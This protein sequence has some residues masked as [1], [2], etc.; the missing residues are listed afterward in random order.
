MTSLVADEACREGSTEQCSMSLLQTRARAFRSDPEDT[1]FEQSA[2]D[3]HRDVKPSL[4][5]H[6]QRNK[7]ISGKYE[8]VKEHV[9]ELVEQRLEERVRA[10]G[11]QLAA[12]QKKQRET[13]QAE[14]AQKAEVEKEAKEAK[15]V[16]VARE[17]NA[18]QTSIAAK[19]AKVAR[20]VDESEEKEGVV[21]VDG[22]SA[23]QRSMEEAAS[24][25]ATA[26]AGAFARDSAKKANRGKNAASDDAKAA[27]EASE[28]TRENKVEERENVVSV[29]VSDMQQAME[30]AASKK[31]EAFEKAFARDA[32]ERASRSKHVVSVTMPAASSVAQRIV[33]SVR[34]HVIG[35]IAHDHQIHADSTNVMEDPGEEGGLPFRLFAEQGSIEVDKQG[36]NSTAS[37]N[38][39]KALHKVVDTTTTNLKKQYDLLNQAM[40]NSS[41]LNTTKNN[42]AERYNLVKGGMTNKLSRVMENY[43][44]VPDDTQVLEAATQENLEH[45][46]NA[47]VKHADA[48]VAADAHVVAEPHVVAATA[49]GAV[50]ATEKDNTDAASK[51]DAHSSSTSPPAAIA[52]D[53]VAETDILEVRSPKS[54][55]SLNRL[56]HEEVLKGRR[57]DVVLA[58]QEEDGFEVKVD[59]TDRGD[60]A[61]FD[62]DTLEQE[63]L[64][65]HGADEEVSDASDNA[66][67]KAEVQAKDA[68]DKTVDKI[69]ERA[70]EKAKKMLDRATPSAQS[71]TK[72]AIQ[73]KR[74]WDSRG[75]AQPN[76]ELSKNDLYPSKDFEDNLTALGG[77]RFKVAKI[78]PT[79]EA[80]ELKL[81]DPRENS[82]SAEME[83]SQKDVQRA[84]KEIAKSAIP[85]VSAADKAAVADEDSTDLEKDSVLAEG[86]D[87]NSA[88]D[89]N[90]LSGS[91]LVTT[92]GKGFTERANVS[93][94]DVLATNA[95]TPLARKA[96]TVEAFA[97]I[98]GKD[99][100]DVKVGHSALQHGD[101][102]N[103]DRKQQVFSQGDLP[104]FAIHDQDDEDLADDQAADPEETGVM[105]DKGRSLSEDVV[106]E[107]RAEEE[108][109]VLHARQDR[110]A[111]DEDDDGEYED[112]HEGEQE[113]EQEP[114]Q[115]S[116]HEGE[117]EDEEDGDHEED[118]HDGDEEGEH[119]S[120][121]DRS[122]D[123][124]EPD[125]SDE[126]GEAEEA[127]GEEEE[128]EEREEEDASLCDPG[129]SLDFSAATVTTN[130][131]G[132]FGPG[133]ASLV[134]QGVASLHGTEVD[135]VVIATS[136]YFARD[137]SKNGLRG[138]FGVVNIQTDT[139]VDLLLTFVSHETG[140]AVTMPPF[141]FTFFDLDQG[142]AHGS[143]EQVTIR[144]FDSYK[145]SDETQLA[146]EALPDGSGA[147]FISRQRGGKLDNPVH[148]TSLTR[149]QRE[150]TVTAKMPATSHFSVSLADSDYAATQ[151]RNFFFSGSSQ[152]VCERDHKCSDYACPDGFAVR[153][154]AE[155][156]L[157]SGR[158]CDDRDRDVCCFRT[159]ADQHNDAAA[160][161]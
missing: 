86:I 44:S 99:N 48:N 12:E 20:E 3:H 5:A 126:H 125:E 87:S 143:R 31:A 29:D 14:E 2:D 91:E 82:D 94:D 101:R 97:N 83:A 17:T 61:E 120:A 9:R 27:K 133:N 49:R 75:N 70:E 1:A 21:S 151:G 155:F 121:E 72:L 90:H 26:A 130:N 32:D 127:Q 160:L 135:L 4:E 13:Q 123:P 103:K 16:R 95:K 152:L 142:M 156:L 63:A 50:A 107:I 76:A 144:G 116:D 51:I 80:K 40:Q 84:F 147:R 139:S 22:E 18:A 93:S 115:E 67:T 154:M 134:Y 145:V 150:R 158:T 74:D 60:D 10:V 141:Y 54:P 64:R 140:Q 73:A 102:S 105:D 129:R 149:L 30:D 46:V 119:E 106:S 98:L 122:E 81:P 104:D 92:A 57:D 43:A 37:S 85:Q 24:K 59:M 124:D 47:T 15:A 89:S 42:L 33:P 56:Y 55:R 35:A 53:D 71:G 137:I 118:E 77:D 161:G 79:V 41:I 153:T 68:L 146:V 148:P 58:H 114:K 39:S 62:I 45:G 96:A 52:R 159:E 11:G 8:S 110:D 7:T 38:A 132:N 111:A 157:C 25:K 69:M 128:E 108:Q 34:R 23:G 138:P 6:L 136:P 112:E 131:L 19:V 65:M 88:Q 113:R 109:V 28:A 100:D 66:L 78:V 117:D 36:S